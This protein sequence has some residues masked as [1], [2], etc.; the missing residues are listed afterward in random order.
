MSDGYLFDL[1]AELNAVS[2]MVLALVNQI[3][4]PRVD[5]LTEECLKSAL[6]GIHCHLNRI[7]GDAAEMDEGFVLVEKG[8]AA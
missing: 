6:H 8:G 1:S 7:A 5:T 4:N 2:C 3:D